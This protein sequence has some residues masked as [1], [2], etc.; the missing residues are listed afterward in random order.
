MSVILIQAFL[1]MPLLAKNLIAFLCT[2][3]QSL[4]PIS[5]VRQAHLAEKES[6][7]K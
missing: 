2:K 1:C 7:G 5:G 3:S 4:S 6:S